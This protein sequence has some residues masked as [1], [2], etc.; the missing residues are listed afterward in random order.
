M[1]RYHFLAGWASCQSGA[2]RMP[3]PQE[4]YL[5]TTILGLPHQLDLAIY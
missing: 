4:L 2:G 1:L 5:C 3:I